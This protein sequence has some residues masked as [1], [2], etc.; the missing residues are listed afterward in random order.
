MLVGIAL[1]AEPLVGLKR[2]RSALGST[3]KQL[4]A[5]PLVGLKRSRDRWFLREARLS[6]EPL[7]G[8]KRVF[9]EGSGVGRLSAEPL[10]GLK[11]VIRDDRQHDGQPFSR[12]PRGFE[13]STVGSAFRAPRLSAEPLVGLKHRKVALRGSRGRLSAEPLVGLKRLSK[14][15]TVT[16]SCFQPNPS[17]V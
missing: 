11:L 8:L 9:D 14:N 17:W 2:V 12:T 5:E 4:S 1:S 16:L 13:A 7:V 6:A 3:Y 15:T 10:V